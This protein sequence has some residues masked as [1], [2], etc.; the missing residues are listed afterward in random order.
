MFSG[1][2]LSWLYLLG[3]LLHAYVASSTPQLVTL[4]ADRVK[5]DLKLFR[6]A[7]HR[8]RPTLRDLIHVS[9]SYLRE[10][11]STY[12]YPSLG[13]C[14]KYGL[15]SSRLGYLLYLIGH[16]PDLSDLVYLVASLEPI[17]FVLAARRVLI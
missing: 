16:E 4:S 1:I 6:C 12:E 8:I 13:P 10:L 3:I 14:V 15:R 2:E 11:A 17:F 7:I 5:N 9:R